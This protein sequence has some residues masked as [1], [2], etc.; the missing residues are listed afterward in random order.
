MRDTSDIDAMIAAVPTPDSLPAA[1]AILVDSAGQIMVMR[2]G[3]RTGQTAT[4][5]DVFNP[6]GHWLG[7]LH[8]PR[9]VRLMEAGSD[10]LLYARFDEDDV[11]HIEV[12]RMSRSP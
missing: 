1:V 12:H 2:E 7:V 3:M 5:V 11:P 6:Q 10:Y 4:L 8:L 9:R